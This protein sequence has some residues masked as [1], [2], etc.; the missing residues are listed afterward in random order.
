MKKT[1]RILGLGLA[2]AMMLTGAAGMAD[3]VFQIIPHND[4][5]LYDENLLTIDS[6]R[7]RAVTTDGYLA[8][9]GELNTRSLV[10]A[11]P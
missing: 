4:A 8:A 1:R 10:K 3:G 5:A 9:H 6:R 2:A 7:W 11:S